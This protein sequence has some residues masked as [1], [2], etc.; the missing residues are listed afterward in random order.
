MENL[1]NIEINKEVINAMNQV[2]FRMINSSDVVYSIT[3][4]KPLEEKSMVI[5]ELAKALS[6]TS[7][8]VCILRVS[9][10]NQDDIPKVQ[11]LNTYLEDNILVIDIIDKSKSV[12]TIYLES[13]GDGIRLLHSEKFKSFVL[14][15]KAM[16]DFVLI[17]T[18][19]LKEGVEGL[20]ITKVTFEKK[21]KF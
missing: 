15:I 20:I 10:Q 17:D 1:N 12:D 13:N 19:A 9:Q 2:A 3:S 16:Y 21:T 5:N 14:E 6:L 11:L 7:K 4:H 8:K 18:P